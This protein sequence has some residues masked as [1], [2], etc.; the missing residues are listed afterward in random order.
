MSFVNELTAVIAEWKKDPIEDECVFQRFRSQA[1]P[2]LSAPDAFE[3]MNQVLR[4]LVDE[5]D[6]STALELLQT[7]LTMARHSQTTEL[8]S[9]LGDNIDV[10]RSRFTA[11]GDYE[12]QKMGELLRYYRVC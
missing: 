6:D 1:I 8:P 9:V 5:K 12:R 2:Q 11:M 10:L 7:V 4:L 3:L